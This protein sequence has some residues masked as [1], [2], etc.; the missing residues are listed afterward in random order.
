MIRVL[1]M[2]LACA[3]ACWAQSDPIAEYVSPPEDLPRQVGPQPIDF[4]HKVHAQVNMECAD[5]HKTATKKFRAG[6]PEPKD[7]MLC[8][9]AVATDHPEIRKLAQLYNGGVKIAWVRV[10]DAPDFVFFSHK[11]HLKAGEECSTCHGPVE[12]RDV[13]AQEISVSMTACMNCHAERGAGNECFL[14]HDLGQ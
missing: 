13:L 2:T 8:H 14:C 12:T 1:L 3:A 10:Y 9:S 5:C 6:L 11:K 7:C 4:S